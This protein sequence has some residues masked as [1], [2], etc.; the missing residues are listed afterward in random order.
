MFV[1]KFPGSMYAT[2]ATKA[3]PKYAHTCRLRKAG[4][5]LNRMRPFMVTA[6][7]GVSVIEQITPSRG[8]LVQVYRSK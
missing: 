1:A 5:H 8:E 4:S 6:G 2:L 7:C 3:G